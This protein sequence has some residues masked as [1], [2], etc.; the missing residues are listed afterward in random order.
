ME[1]IKPCSKDK[2]SKKHIEHVNCRV[3]CDVVFQAF[4]IW[5]T[6]W[7]PKMNYCGQSRCCREITDYSISKIDDGVAFAL[8]ETMIYGLLRELDTK[9]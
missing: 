5:Y 4:L 1:Q 9:P 7:D 3:T 6:K 2:K 8:P